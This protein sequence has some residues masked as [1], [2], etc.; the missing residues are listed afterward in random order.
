MC[1][2]MTGLYKKSFPTATTF[3]T[4]DIK[5]WRN[6][7]E[8]S[9]VYRQIFLIFIWQLVCG[10]MGTYYLL[11]MAGGSKIIYD[12]PP[13]D[14]W[15]DEGKIYIDPPDGKA[16]ARF[17]CCPIYFLDH[18]YKR[19]KCSSL[20]VNAGW[21]KF[22]CL[23]AFIVIC[24]PTHTH[25]VSGRLLEMCDSVAVPAPPASYGRLCIWES[26]TFFFS[27]WILDDS[28]LPGRYWRNFH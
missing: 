26:G 9:L 4:V 15:R 1:V 5:S 12:T 11:F 25:A 6:K 28:T 17:L 7:R 23:C 24:R 8:I 21:I 22:S 14:C 3:V 27:R 10:C 18:V 19:E 13:I 16:A 2:C 20:K